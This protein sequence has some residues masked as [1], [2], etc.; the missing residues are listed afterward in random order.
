MDDDAVVNVEEEPAIQDA[1]SPPATKAVETC[2]VQPSTLP[3]G[4]NELLF[5][6]EYRLQALA[7]LAAAIG[8]DVAKA[9]TETLF[10]GG[11]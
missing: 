2:D 9:V 4:P 10:Y 5:E 3:A 11:Q 1:T 7:S 6:I 8:G